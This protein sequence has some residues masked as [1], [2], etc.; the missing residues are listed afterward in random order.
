MT[1]RNQLYLVVAMRWGGCREEQSIRDDAEYGREE[2]RIKASM[3]QKILV[4]L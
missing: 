1:S 4:I 2:W 3:I